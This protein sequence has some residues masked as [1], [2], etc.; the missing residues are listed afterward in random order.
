MTY[1]FYPTASRLTRPPG[2][3]QRQATNLDPADTTMTDQS[4]VQ[5]PMN[6]IH[7]SMLTKLDP[8]FVDLYNK[9]L[10]YSLPS[11]LS[12]NR[13]R[14]THSIQYSYATATGPEVARV[15]NLKV[16]G[17]RRYP[18]SITIRLYIPKGEVPPGGWPIHVNFHGGG[19]CLGDLD[20]EA[21]IC[22][23]ICS[24]TSVVVIDVK[25]RLVP[26]IPFPTA[27]YDCFEV[28]KLVKA[29]GE[30]ASH[31][32]L[33]S[34]SLSIGGLDVG[35]T[36]ALILNHLA[37]DHVPAFSV[38][39]VIAGMPRLSN[40][41]DINKPEDSPFASMSKM[42]LA[43]ITNFA[44]LKWTDGFRVASLASTD[45]L[46]RERQQEEV[47]WFENIF[48]APSFLNLAPITWICTASCSPLRDEGE[49]YGKLLQ[50]RDNQVMVKR[51]EGV[52]QPFPHMDAV[53]PQA[54]QYI[55]DICAQIRKA[56][57]DT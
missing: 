56:H 17:W 42:A 45:S 32:N 38:M 36:I 49:A 44:S 46:K 52:P 10:A 18:G 2:S 50:D 25:Y 26:E 47:S 27:V 19:F 39:A 37:R 48:D 1:R 24:K 51:Y 55:E 15:Y 12:L 14:Q 11:V 20:T 54:Q 31:Y 7:P 53:L 9:N 23:K 16:P 57:Y 22:K 3:S 41:A 33:D 35:A 34:G 30:F 43:P 21:H 29:C 40:M 6:P 4:E 13:L 5:G 28:L 8:M